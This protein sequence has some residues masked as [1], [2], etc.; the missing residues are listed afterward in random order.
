MWKSQGCFFLFLLFVFFVVFFLNPECFSSSVSVGVFCTRRG[1]EWVKQQRSDS[2]GNSHTGLVQCL[3]D[4]DWTGVFSRLPR[5]KAYIGFH[6]GCS[7]TRHCSAF[8]T[9]R[10]G[11][12]TAALFVY[13]V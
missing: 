13:N 3:I 1:M 8:L 4:E 12:N 5:T 6:A 7:F 9:K 10:P 2:G 11:G